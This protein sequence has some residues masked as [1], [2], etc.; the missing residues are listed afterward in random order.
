MPYAPTPPLASGPARRASRSTRLRI[1]ALCL[2][3]PLLAACG[4]ERATPEPTP[5]AAQTV[6]PTPT[7]APPATEPSATPDTMA[8]ENT[9]TTPSGLQYT[10]IIAGTGPKPQ[11]GDVVAVH[12]TGTL[13]DGTV[14]D[15]SYNRGEPLRFALGSGMVIEG[16][17]EGIGLMNQGGQALLV[18]PPH[19]AYGERGAGNVIPPDATLV[20]DVELVDVSAGAPAAPTALEDDA[21]TTTAQGVKVADLVVG[22]GPSPMPGQL[23]VVHYTGWLEDG[24][25]FDSSLDRGEPFSF[26]IGMGQVIAGWDLGLVG[27]KVGGKRQLVIPPELGY[28]ADGAGNVIPPDA[29]LIFEVELLELK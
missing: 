7:P 29:T 20:F 13:E 11:P 26:N 25:K 1:V 9:M 8:Q 15:S 24:G 10:E 5:A 21:Y 14:F 16:W 19:L 3:I 6:D 12:Y 23:V 17:D 22:D 27:M 18:I 2:L 4:R 28:G